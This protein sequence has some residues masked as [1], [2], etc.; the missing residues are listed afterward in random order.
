MAPPLQKAESFAYKFLATTED[1]T[2][3]AW[4]F[5]VKFVIFR[6]SIDVNGNQNMKLQ[7]HTSKAICVKKL[8]NLLGILFFY[9][10]FTILSSITLQAQTQITFRQLSVKEGLSQNSAISIAQDS[11]G[12]LW[13]ATQDGLNKY[14]GRTFTSYPYT[15]VDITKPDYSNLGK[16]YTDRQGGLWIIPMDRIPRKLNPLTD[17]FEPLSNISDASTIYQDT[18]LTI[19]IGTYSNGLYRLKS[20]IKVPTRTVAPTEITGTIFE[21]AQNTSRELLLATEKEIV[22]YDSKGTTTEH[23]KPKNSN[24]HT[25]EQNFSSLVYDSNETL[26][27]GTYGDGLYFKN[28]SESIFHRVSELSLI[29]DLPDNLN[30]IDLH[31]DSKGRIWV[32]S[33]GNGLYLID[34]E[35]KRITHFNAEKY[36]PKA[37]HYNDILC[38]HEDYS[39]TL[40]FGTDGAG[41]S[42]YDEYL[43]KFNSLTNSQTPDE[44]NID[45]VR[46]ITVDNEDRVW[47]GTSGKGLTQYEQATET[48][49]TFRDDNTNNAIVSDRIMSLLVAENGHIWIGT[50]GGG[51]SILNPDGNFSNFSK[52]SNPS[53]SANTIWCIYK[54]SENRMW[55]GTRE[56]GLVQFDSNKGEIIKYRASSDGLSSNNIRAIT[57]DAKGNLWIGTETDGISFF[58]VQKKTFKSYEQTTNTNSLSNNNIKSLYFDQ[59]GLLWIGT[60]GGGLNAFDIENQRFYSYTVENGLANNVIYA[61]LPDEAGNLWLSS[62]KGITKFTLGAS[63]AS[64]PEITNY[65]NYAGLATEFNTGAFHKDGN[66]NLYFGGLEG[67]YWFRPNEIKENKILPKTTITGFEVSNKSFPILENTR[68]AHDQNTLSFTFSSL[69]YSLPEKNAYQYR[70][71]NYDDDWVQAGNTNFAR[72]TQLPSG[73]YTFQVKSSNY[74][75]VW[76]EVPESFDFV[77]ASPWYFTLYA[78][79]I[80]GILLLSSVLG[81]YGYL[82]WRWQMQLSLRLKEEETERLKKLNDFKSNLYT[83]IAHEFKTPLTLIS[84]PIDQKLSQGNLSDFDHANFSIVK[85]NTH[86]LT[87]LVDQLLELAKL[88]DGKLQLQLQKGDL[89]LFL[90]TISQSFEYQAYLKDIEY[91]V[92]IDDLGNVW[93]D[94]DIVEKI[95]TNLL[96]NAFKYAPKQGICHF[97][98]KKDT[99]FA[100]I[101]VKNTAVNASKLELKKLFTRFYQHDEYSDGMG[102][103][104]SLVQE[105]VKFYRGTIEARIEENDV[106]H[107]ELRLP[108]RRSAF[109]EDTIKKETENVNK[110]ALQ[111]DIIDADYSFSDDSKKEHPILLIVED[112]QEVRTFIKLALQKKYR[113]LEAENGKTG[114]EIALSQIPDIILS[115]IRMPFKNGI[116]L[117][118]VLKTDERTSH[119]PI[120]LLTA[121]VGEEDELKGLTSGADD[122]VRK[123]FK[124]NI[125]VQRIAN[126][127][128]IR[129]SLRDRYSQELILKPK[130]ISITPGDEIFLDKIQSILDEH[131]SDPEFNSEAFSKKAKMSRM[132][133]HRKLL[134]YTG[135]STSAFIRSQRLKQALQLLKT[136]HLTINEVAYSVGF[137]TPSYFMKCFKETFKKTP[138]EYLQNIEN[139]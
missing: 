61:I 130:D 108:T 129:R 122:F 85:R 16:V 36:N 55:L 62:N 116:E 121:S 111:S 109:P 15:F 32:A 9:G 45:V 119:I 63:L 106:I 104:L 3:K 83:D 31:I 48:W 57:E 76:N 103:G 24:G 43:E 110:T 17:T 87:S 26:W 97:S 34:L 117:C 42:Y 132:Q 52:A 88:E 93:Y 7:G 114:M 35:R 50:Q 40:W 100:L 113:I 120:I 8:S 99:Q 38:I 82:K 28:T 125:L 44:V 135:L 95:T 102:V 5:L 74:D 126:L 91:S 73:D 134:A 98:V 131:L 90:H 37:L 118:N 29:G 2:T 105:L 23:L 94:E 101:S 22:I 112:H 107:F 68:L 53:L 137:N 139:Q 123:P 65:T 128:A 71:V 133:L 86:R 92:E 84:G 46:A 1:I 59:N 70:L 51:L 18:D 64:I 58:D 75:G 127:V 60:N 13:I 21:I 6:N 72:Y 39:G 66:G 30:V 96:S 81:V 25:I 69:Q 27:V 80:Y 54:D 77:I 10:L 124:I 33:Y 79:I 78:K 136:S 41:I 67:F 47:I 138:S 14:D 20:G 115:D 12:Y 89:S 56:Q 49:R 4:L 11:T 19:W